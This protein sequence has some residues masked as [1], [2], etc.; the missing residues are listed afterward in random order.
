MST[1]PTAPPSRPA[2]TTNPATNSAGWRIQSLRAG[3][4]ATQFGPLATLRLAV[5]R[6]WPYL[7]DGSVDEEREYLAPYIGSAGGLA[8][9][10]WAGDTVVG[11]STALPLP[12]AHAEFQAPFRAAGEPVESILYFG[13]SVVLPEWRGRGLGRAFFAA[14]E[15]HA[16]TLGLGECVFCAVDRAADDP[17]RPADYV[18]NA[19]FWAH[20]G[21]QRDPGRVCRF[22]WTDLGDGAPS[23]KT[24]TFWRRRLPPA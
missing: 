12:H 15:A 22:E 8:L 19:R 3:D 21:Y 6:E 5:F 23:H 2:A 11:A 20:R 13:E 9:L 14:R 24:L 1:P 18:G 7:Y 16:R 10:A 4:I 17:R